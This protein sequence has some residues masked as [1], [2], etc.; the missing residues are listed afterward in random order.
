MHSRPLALAAP[1]V[2]LG[3]LAWAVAAPDDSS[4]RTIPAGVARI[5]VTPEEP[6]RLCGYAARQEPFEDVARPLH[7]KALAL[8]GEGEQPLSLLVTVD[9]IGVPASLTEALAKRLESQLDL[10]RAHLTVAASHTHAAPTL[11]DCIPFLFDPPLAG[12]EAE[13]VDR[14]TDRLLDDIEAVALE[15]AAARRPCRL[16]WG[17]GSVDFAVNRRLL[18]EDGQWKGFGHQPDGPVDHSLPLLRVDDESGEPVAVLVNYAC[19]CTTMGGAFN[20]VHGDW[21][22]AAQAAIEERH[23]GVTALVAIGCG[24]DQ[25]PDPRGDLDDAAAHGE[26]VAEEATRLMNAELAPVSAAPRATY[27]EIELPLQEPPPRETWRRKAEAGGRGSHFAG[28][29]LTKLEAGESVAEPVPLPVQTWAFGEDLAMVF[30]GGEVVVDYALRLYRDH[31]ADR[32]W[33]NAY[34][35]ALPGYIPSNRLFPQG[36][37]EVDSSRFSYGI[38]A[39]LAVETENRIAAEVARQLP[40]AFSAKTATR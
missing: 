9:A 36:G 39:R 21:A 8:G 2:L 13:A 30:L 20:R 35:N 1:F 40:A 22:G 26:A 15:A 32:I 17:K 5:D 25:N 24:G 11:R 27:R 37:Y 23:P 31:D 10:D 7:A 34:S 33:V 6:L 16:S 19:H 28:T 18:D 38:P 29:I 14:Y 12:A 3:L 4:T